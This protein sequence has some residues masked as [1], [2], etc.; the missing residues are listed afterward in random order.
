MERI[1]EVVTMQIVPLIKKKEELGI[2]FS[3][4]G[5]KEL[6]EYH[7]KV[8]KQLERLRQMISKMDATVAKKVTK[9]MA[10]E[11]WLLLY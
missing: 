6:I 8:G 1:S 9:K 7:E 5:K 3:D 4:E 2:D 11:I 10:I